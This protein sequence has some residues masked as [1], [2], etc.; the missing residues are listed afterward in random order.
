MSSML[1]R[2]Y[3]QSAHLNALLN[4]NPVETM[5]QAREIDL[6]IYP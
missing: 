6:R 4:S 1:D 5:K 2:F 3:E